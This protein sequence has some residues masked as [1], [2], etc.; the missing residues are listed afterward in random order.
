MI[1]RAFAWQQ[2]SSSSAKKERNPLESSPI[3]IILK[4]RNF[5]RTIIYFLAYILF[6][7]LYYC[8]FDIF[9]VHGYI[10]GIYLFKPHAIPTLDIRRNQTITILFKGIHWGCWFQLEHS[11]WS[12][13][14]WTRNAIKFAHMTV[15]ISIIFVKIYVFF[16]QEQ[17][18]LRIKYRTL[19]Q[20]SLVKTEGAVFQKR[21]NFNVCAPWDLKG[22]RARWQV[23]INAFS[24]YLFIIDAQSLFARC[25]SFR[26]A[27]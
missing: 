2:I 9:N 6:A 1:I 15:S 20:A 22:Q 27:K 26:V 7:F 10:R 16:L 5:Y 4:H 21:T 11:I 19:V 23:C 13:C 14:N 24:S 8:Y 3:F 25:D 17:L 18:R 12:V